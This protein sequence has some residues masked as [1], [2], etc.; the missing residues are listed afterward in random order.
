MFLATCSSLKHWNPRPA[1]TFLGIS[2]SS[3]HFHCT[4]LMIHKF[5]KIWSQILRSSALTGNAQAL[6]LLF[7]T[8]WPWTRFYKDSNLEKH[9]PRCKNIGWQSQASH[10]PCSVTSSTV[11]Q[12]PVIAGAGSSRGRKVLCSVTTWL[13]RISISLF[14]RLEADNECPARWCGCNSLVM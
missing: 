3:Q 4:S 2:F 10:L 14:Q 13:A 6:L 9:I 11:K 8:C 12:Q 7:S 1:T 5:N